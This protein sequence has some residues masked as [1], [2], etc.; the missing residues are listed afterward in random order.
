MKKIFV[1]I[2]GTICTLTNGEY[3]KAQPIEDRIKA[4]NELYESGAHIVYWTA[5]GGNS[6]KDWT[7]L[8]EQQLKDWGC[9]YHEIKMGKP[10]YDFYIDDK[11]F[12]SDRYFAGEYF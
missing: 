3:E 5:R 12:N 11:S 1:D 8:T 2:D 4:I 10:A 7:Q 6:G 9:K